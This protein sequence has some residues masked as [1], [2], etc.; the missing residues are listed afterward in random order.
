MKGVIRV[1]D[2]TSHGGQV[3]TGCE[4]Y[5]VDGKPVARVGDECTCP[6]HGHTGVKIVEGHVNIIVDGKP[7]ALHGFKT[8]CGATLITSMEDH[9]AEE[10]A[11]GNTAKSTKPEP[12]AKEKSK[13]KITSID[14]AKKSQKKTIKNQNQQQVPQSQKRLSGVSWTPHFSNSN[15]ISTLTDG[16]RQKAE[17]FVSALRDAGASVNISST[18]RPPKR[19]YLMHY[20]WEISKNKLNP[21][22]VPHREGVDIEWVHKN[23]NGSIDIALSRSAANDMVDSY[24]IVHRPS[25]TSRHTEGKAIDMT[26]SWKGDL[27]IRKAN[28]EMITIKGGPKNGS[29]PD[30][31]KVGA[32]Y[33]VIKLKSDPPHWS[34]DGH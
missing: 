18:L 4:K 13:N 28:G 11:N 27:H 31:I 15:D 10:M 17:R 14:H 1:G 33:G 12:N 8:S 34:N 32:A 22:S 26:I 20:S 16:F 30:L 23:A 6:I 21:A 3:V 25:L 2:R 24:K 7:L 5:L 19:A 9:G 29:N